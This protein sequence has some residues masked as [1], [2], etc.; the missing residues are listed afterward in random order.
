MKE[1]YTFTLDDEEI[2]SENVKTQIKLVAYLLYEKLNELDFESNNPLLVQ[3]NKLKTNYLYERYDSEYIYRFESEYSNYD[4][5]MFNP[6]IID[7]KSF[8]I[9]VNAGMITIEDMALMLNEVT[10]FIKF[11]HNFNIDSVSYIAYNKD[12]ESGRLKAIRDIGKKKI[13]E[14]VNV[15]KLMP[16]F[17]SVKLIKDNL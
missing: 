5:R 6:M 12:D 10:K 2:P 17:R 7:D 13:K 9:T 8:G 15:K 3:N 16:I 4:S 14:K 11:N 1:I